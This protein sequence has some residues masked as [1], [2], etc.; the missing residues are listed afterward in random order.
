MTRIVE[1]TLEVNPKRR[2]EICG[3]Q[4]AGITAKLSNGDTLLACYVCGP[5]VVD[6]IIEW[7]N[8]HGDVD[9]DLYLGVKIR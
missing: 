7:Y 9:P 2:C 1:Y 8:L 3:G 4:W 6:R 5:A